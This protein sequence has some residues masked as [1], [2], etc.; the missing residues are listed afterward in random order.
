MASLYGRHLSLDDVVVLVEIQVA[1]VKGR[2]YGA[3]QRCAMFLSGISWT[4]WVF[5]LGSPEGSAR[6]SNRALL[7]TVML[8]ADMASAPNSGRS[9][10]PSDG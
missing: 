1:P 4:R 3:N 8:D 5:Q 2:H 7:T 10:S 6:R 9:I